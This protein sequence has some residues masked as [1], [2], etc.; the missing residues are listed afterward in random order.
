MSTTSSP[1]DDGTPVKQESPEPFDKRVCQVDLSAKSDED[2]SHSLITIAGK[3]LDDNQYRVGQYSGDTRGLPAFTVR[4]A[5]S[6]AA[7]FMLDV[8][9]QD[10]ARH[11]IWTRI[12]QLL[13]RGRSLRAPPSII[14]S[15]RI[16][17]D[18]EREAVIDIVFHSLSACQVID[19]LKEVRL[20]GIEGESHVFSRRA[21]T[22][23]LPGNVIVVQCAGLPIDSLD[24][25]ALFAAFKA[26]A[27]PVG[28]VLGIAKIVIASKRW[29]L[30][31][32]YSGAVRAQVEFKP[33]IMALPWNEVLLRL[34][35]HLRCNGFPYPLFY[36]SRYLHAENVFS[37]DF[38]IVSPNESTRSKA[39]S[40]D[41][42]TREADE[43]ADSKI[44]V[45][46]KIKRNKKESEEEEDEE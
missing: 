5:S 37:S 9:K 28:T 10:K 17:A 13:P 24:P 20:D 34:P 35:T 23:Q 45:A 15:E 3:C 29:N 25:Q 22:S 2:L 41:K 42:R 12:E 8:S 36:P 33:E 43:A 30:G 26:I 6:M 11:A 4:F 18:D 27:K 16:D 32:Q 44:E 21:C 7:S 40:S 31:K 1:G 39:A 46:K 19:D 38:T 14:F